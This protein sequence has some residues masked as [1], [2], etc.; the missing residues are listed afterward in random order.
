MRLLRL[1]LLLLGASVGVCIGWVC[2]AYIVAK[3]DWESRLVVTQ[4]FLFAMVASGFTTGTI[5]ALLLNRF[6]RG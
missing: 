4:V 6:L 3:I 1:I 2:A 5:T